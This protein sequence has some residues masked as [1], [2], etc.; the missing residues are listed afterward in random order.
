[1][2]W[3]MTIRKNFN[4]KEEEAKRLESMARSEGKTQTE[5]VLEALEHYYEA[6]RARERREAFVALK[7]SLSGKIG[8][9]DLKKEREK[10]L[11]ERYG[12]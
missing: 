6:K 10:V 5:V 2:R 11:A 1:M 8:D 12:G 7:G 9:L 4:F 3:A